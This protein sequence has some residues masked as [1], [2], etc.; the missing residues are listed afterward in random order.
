MNQL[1]LCHEPLA[2]LPVNITQTVADLVN[3]TKLHNC[4]RKN[5]ADGVFKAVYTNADILTQEG[6]QKAH[7]DRGRK[8]TDPTLEEL[9]TDVPPNAP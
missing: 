9:G 2:V 6:E 8:R 3:D 7:L 4:L 5:G 1:Q